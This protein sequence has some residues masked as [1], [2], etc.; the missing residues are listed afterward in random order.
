MELRSKE[1]GLTA[2]QTLKADA[3]GREQG[4]SSPPPCHLANP[5]SPNLGNTDEF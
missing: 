3:P 5:E 1:E 4:K 2:E